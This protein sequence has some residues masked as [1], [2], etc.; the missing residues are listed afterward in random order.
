[1]H[2]L[3]ITLIQ[4]FQKFNYNLI[5]IFS[6]LFFLYYSR[7]CPEESF[8]KRNGNYKPL[9]VARLSL[10]NT[11]AGYASTGVSIS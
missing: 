10:I 11:V 6:L 1:M 8:I 4:N 2:V 9:T 3:F 7:Y 5:I